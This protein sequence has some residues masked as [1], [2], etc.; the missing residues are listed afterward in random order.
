[1]ILMSTQENLRNLSKAKCWLMDGTFDVVPSIM[2]QLFTIHAQI[3]NQVVPLVY[4]LMSKK[5]IV[6]YEEVFYE[7]MFHACQYGLELQPDTIISDFEKASVAAAKSYF[8]AA[9]FKGCLFHLGQILWRRVQHLGLAKKYGTDEAFSLSV[10]M[11]L[12]L[13]F[14]EPELIPQYF[15]TLYGTLDYDAKRLARWFRANYI[16]SKRK[17]SNYVPEFWSIAY[18]VRLNLPKT[19][20]NVEAWHRRLQAIIGKSH[21]GVYAIIEEMGAESIYVSHRIQKI[22]SGE[23][24][25]I[26]KK[27][28]IR[29]RQIKRIFKKR[30]AYEPIEFL[31]NLAYR[32]VLA[33]MH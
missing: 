22:E 17:N 12:C 28:V 8:P 1:M 18:N 30:T 24:K 10:R 13:A 5:S 23:S 20:N 25:A 6:A 2:Q 31:K 26:K 29:N 7:L 4:C 9:T 3:G 15:Q 19:T 21:I 11:L 33:G 16:G 27:Q 32:N 14:V